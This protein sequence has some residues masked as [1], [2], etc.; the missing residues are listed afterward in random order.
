MGGGMNSENFRIVYE[1]PEFKNGFKQ[2][3]D[4]SMRSFGDRAVQEM[5]KLAPFWTGALVESL[6][7]VKVGDAHYQIVAGVPYAMRRNFENNLHPQTLHYI[8]RGV[9]NIMDGTTARWWKS[10]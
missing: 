7:V 10:E 9:E 1:S 3:L 5:S 4:T 8:E 6:A 2:S